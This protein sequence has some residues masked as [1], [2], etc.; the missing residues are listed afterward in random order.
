MF[1]P[2]GVEVFLESIEHHLV[3]G[4]EGPTR[5]G[6]DPGGRWDSFLGMPIRLARIWWDRVDIGPATR[7]DGTVVEP[8]RSVELPTALRLDFDAGPVWLVAAMPRGQAMED[9]FGLADEIMVVFSS[10]KM[11]RMG[12]IDA[13]FIRQGLAD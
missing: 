3:L 6:P 1:Y 9:V 7:V 13:G 8:A 4:Q 5:N 11:H 12:Y 10:A 2:Y